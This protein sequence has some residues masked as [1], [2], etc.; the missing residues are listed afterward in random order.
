MVQRIYIDTSVIGGLFDVEFSDDTK[1]FF[2]RVEKGEI[3]IVYSEITI[4]ELVK[5]FNMATKT[6][7][8]EKNFHA[9]TFMREQGDKISKD[10]ANMDFKEIKEYFSKRK[11]TKR[12]AAKH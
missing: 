6:I 3:K 2:D 7:S 9:V 12:P 5:R 4:D 11:T 1:P 10:I 8:I